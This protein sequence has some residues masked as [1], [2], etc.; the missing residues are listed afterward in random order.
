MKEQFIIPAKLR[1]ISIILF[2][3]GILA[4]GIGIFTLNGDQ[5]ATR[6]W[7][8]LMFNSIFFMLI[9]LGA[10]IVLC[11][12][13]LAQGTWH[14]AYKRVIEAMVMAL[15]V[16][17]IVAFIVM[18]CVVWGDKYHIYEWVD[19]NLVA[20]DHLLQKKSAFLNP[21]FYT[22]LTIMTIGIWSLLGFRLRKL[23][24]QE[25][26]ADKGTTKIFWK[27]YRWAAVFV[28]FFA[29]TN[30]TSSWQWIMSIDVDWFSTLFAWYIF[31]SLFVCAMAV[32]AL[33]I[34]ILRNY[35]YLEWVTFEHLHDLGKFMFA[36]SIFWTYLWFAQFI[37]IWY[38]NIPEETI[39]YSI[40]MWGSYHTMFYLIL[41]LNFVAPFLILMTRDSKRNYTI[42][43]YMALL[44]FI[45]HYLDFFMMF[46]P[47]TV[48]NGWHLSW[49]ELGISLGFVGLF[50]FVVM[51]SLAKAPLYPKNHP[52]L[53]EAI[54]H[55]S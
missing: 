33:F 11:A 13:T 51:R 4:L 34:I 35:G 46:M 47:G 2:V 15:P 45:V 36:F 23:S 50:I 37:L 24:L 27:S 17:G 10:L 55:R 42:V 43:A 19:K 53:K 6:F 7:S 30:S 31:S 1:T 20:N 48:K 26:L 18:M 52:Y 54:I 3:I 44:V 9:A 25:D 12:A 49:Y 41:L 14:I 39:Y 40:R 32:L 16:L 29:I 8:V 28:V 38:G 21:T 22:I 5:G